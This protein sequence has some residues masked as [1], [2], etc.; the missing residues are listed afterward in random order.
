MIFINNKFSS[1]FM[2]KIVVWQ[3]YFNMREEKVYIAKLEKPST[4]LLKYQ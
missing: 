1:L 4:S 2:L 3:F